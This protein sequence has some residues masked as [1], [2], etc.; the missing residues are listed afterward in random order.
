VSSFTV[1][2]L[3]R[4]NP[5]EGFRR[6]AA[7]G[8]LV[9]VRIGWGG[10]LLIVNH[11]A[12][13]ESVLVRQQAHFVKGRALDLARPLLGNGL[14]TS[15]G[16]LWR[17][18]RQLSQPAFA[19]QTVVAHAPTIVD[20]TE[21]A[22]AGWS[23]GV[24]LDLAREVTRLTLAVVA[25]SFLGTDLG[26]AADPFR[27]DLLW[28]LRDMNRQLERLWPTPAWLPSPTRRR[29]LA[30]AGRLETVVQDI[31]DRRPA[32]G[33]KRP[34]EAGAWLAA[35]AEAGTLPHIRRQLRDEI[36]TVLLAGH[37]TTASVLVWCWYLLLRHDSVRA[38][39]TDELRT[40]LQGRSPTEAD[41]SRLP[42]TAAVL[43]ETL[44]LYPPAWIIL[45]KAVAPFQLGA[46]T[47][48]ADTQV[49]LSQWVTHRDPRFWPDAASFRPERWLG[50]RPVTHPF[51]YFP[52]GGGPRLCI[53]RPF[54]LMEAS[55]M[56]AVMAQ[57][58]TLRLEPR[59]PVE[60]EAL[61]TLRPRHGL[62]VTVTAV[63]PR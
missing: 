48:P 33:P 60:L 42:Y 18:Q 3:L 58:V 28:L 45:R 27:D 31:I 43:R 40:V 26:P 21:E 38:R 53:G 62:P 16:P 50:D 23:P 37:D 49:A 8:D 25:R 57:R 9:T 54:A 47:W 56:L 55:L 30:A 15:D 32:G 17:R 29:R 10:T 35:L 19:R 39:L 14:L 59:P 1:W 46:V 41:V 7:Y 5:P 2:R 12:Y 61:V 34:S 52:F 24:R 44:R 20:L 6:L 4:R 36:M 13:V 22:V 11:P 51:A 63:R